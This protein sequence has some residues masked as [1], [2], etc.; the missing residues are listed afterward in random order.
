MKKLNR[1]LCCLLL[2]ICCTVIAGESVCAYDLQEFDRQRKCE[3]E[4]YVRNERKKNAPVAG[5]D[6]TLY[7]V[8]DVTFVDSKVRYDCTNDF[9]GYSRTL[10]SVK[11]EEI[12]DKLFDYAVQN[13]LKGTTQYTDKNGKTRFT[14][15]EAGVYLVAEIKGKQEYVRFKPFI[16]VLPF[17]DKGNWVFNV[18]AM[19]KYDYT[20]YGEDVISIKVRK[21][22]NDDGKN[23]P[24][25][26]TV[27]LL[28]DGEVYDTVS[29]SEES[30]WN[31]EWVKLEKD[32]N[33][34]V[35]EEHIPDGYYVTYS[36][37]STGYVISNTRP[38]VQTGQL[39]WPIPVLASGGLVF[40]IIGIII[41]SGRD[42]K[43]HE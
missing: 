31:H 5:T 37:D 6:V 39:R 23:R 8:A 12:A 9:V 1:I 21:V 14:G 36:K 25:S 35:K 26:I 29:L 18:L 22:W 33:W 17:D 13:R 41:R 10:D 15:L 20:K 19:P 43:K 2:L 34:T 24:D 3:L 11:S 4:I 38:L 42:K 28:C 27:Q 40:I 32:K 30:G 7:R 16:A